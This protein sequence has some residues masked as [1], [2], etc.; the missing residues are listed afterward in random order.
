MSEPR[1][2]AFDC[3]RA[4]QLIHEILDGDTPESERRQWLGD[5]RSQ[6]AECQAFEADLRALQGALRALPERAF[7]EEALD[8]VWERTVRG[9]VQTATRSWRID[10]RSFAVAAALTAAAFGLWQ[11]NRNDE[12]E[13]P[14][15]TVG[16]IVIDPERV[17]NDPEYARR[18][19]EQTR[20]VLG[21]TS[22]ALRRTEQAA[23]HGILAD[24]V[25]GALGRVPV[26]WPEV[27]DAQT[28]RNRQRENEL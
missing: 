27:D 25:G 26:R 18:I 15:Q 19:A 3:H 9:Q 10:W 24:E 1:E 7:P 5:H 13:E 20:R 12:P 23:L 14:L 4:R 8:C 6:C 28:E 22:D 11:W 16:L 17:R 2:L 21:L